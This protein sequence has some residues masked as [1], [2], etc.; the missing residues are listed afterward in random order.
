MAAGPI[1]AVW[2]SGTWSA[3]AWEANTWADEAQA[4]AVSSRGFLILTSAH[5][6][7][8]IVYPVRVFVG[9]EFVSNILVRKYT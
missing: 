6:I 7:Q 1:G 3:T 2:G 5:A 8:A 9:N 4:T